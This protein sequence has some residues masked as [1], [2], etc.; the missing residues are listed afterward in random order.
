MQHTSGQEETGDD[1]SYLM[2][3]VGRAFL[4]T[5]APLISFLR[6]LIDDA[7]IIGQVKATHCWL[8][9]DN[10]EQTEPAFVRTERSGPSDLPSVMNLAVLCDMCFIYVCSWILAFGGQM[11]TLAHA[12]C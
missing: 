6:F 7:K 1:P 3:I 5:F 4:L 12:M 11:H 9:T 2:R 10:P 8:H